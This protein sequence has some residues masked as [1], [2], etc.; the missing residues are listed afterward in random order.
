MP[1][2]GC[3][4]PVHD[5]TDSRVIDKD[6][7]SAGLV[8]SE[9][10][11]AAGGFLSLFRWWRRPGAPK[12]KGRDP[13]LEWSATPT[14]QQ[15]GFALALMSSKRRGFR[16]SIRATLTISPGLA[17]PAPFA[18]IAGARDEVQHATHAAGIDRVFLSR[19]RS[20]GNRRRWLS[21]GSRV[22][23]KLTETYLHIVPDSLQNPQHFLG[24]GGAAALQVVA[25]LMRLHLCS[26][27]I[28]H[29]V[30]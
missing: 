3:S 7:T 30:P 17:V 15:R 28:L 16:A 11:G 12:C 23:G 14:K 22:K 9:T 6:G 27:R 29:T 13:A 21:C 19:H 2:L 10:N 18:P 1:A 8:K 25:H 20:S 26:L 4:V 5:G 24:E